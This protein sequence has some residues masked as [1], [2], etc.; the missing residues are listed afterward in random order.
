MYGLQKFKQANVNKAD[1]VG[2]IQT[3]LGT[4]APKVLVLLELPRFRRQF[5]AC[6]LGNTQVL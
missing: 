2:K 6:G 1:R 3:V 4:I 5:R